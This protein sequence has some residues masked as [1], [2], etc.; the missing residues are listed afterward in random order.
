MF[1]GGGSMQDMMMMMAIMQLL[2]GNQN[3]NSPQSP[4]D[5]Q[6]GSNEVVIP[7]PTVTPIPSPVPTRTSDSR[8]TSSNTST[9]ISDADIVSSD[10]DAVRDDSS[11]SRGSL[12]GDTIDDEV[13]AA[14][15]PRTAEWERK[16]EGIF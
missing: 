8:G 1:G 10:E 2:N 11:D 12:N 14:E 7:T 15:T 3:Q 9:E 5:G 13:T 16:R 4:V 6:P